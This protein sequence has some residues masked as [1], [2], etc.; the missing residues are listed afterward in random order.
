M[1]RGLPLSKRTK[2]YLIYCLGLGLSDRQFLDPLEIKIIVFIIAYIGTSN[3]H[4]EI[5]LYLA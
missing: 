2:K 4:V 1:C 5:I 3:A